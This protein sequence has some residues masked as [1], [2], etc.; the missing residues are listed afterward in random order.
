MSI[1]AWFSEK[2]VAP[3][4]HYYTPEATIVYGL[5]LAVA[6]WGTYKLLR[7]FKIA[8]DKRFF[9]GILPFIIWGGWTRALVDHGLGGYTEPLWCSPPIYIWTFLIAMAGLLTGIAIEKISKKK[10]SYHIIFGSVGAVLLLYNLMFT[11]ITNWPAISTIVPL[12]IVW[13][14]LFF[15]INRVKPKWL[16]FENAGI[17]V[18]HGLD[19]SSTFTAISYFGY[20]EQHVVPTFVINAL[21]PWAFFPL[22]FGVI[23]AVLWAVDKYGEDRFFK[24]FLKIVI[25]ILGLAL[26]V[27]GFLTV[28]MLQV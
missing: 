14:I 1:S 28:G 24:N 6:V 16:S 26:G 7:R 25:L 17:L 3:L 22:K 21:G 13:A 23:W 8:I 20:Y 15:G 18:A 5:V 27:R 19:V 4:C 10:I 2:F 11:G 9:W 12:V